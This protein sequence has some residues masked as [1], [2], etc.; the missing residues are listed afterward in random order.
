MLRTI[1]QGPNGDIGF[2]ISCSSVG[3]KGVA[4][5]TSMESVDMLGK[6]REIS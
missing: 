6:S 1:V 5:R 3:R 4:M 2:V